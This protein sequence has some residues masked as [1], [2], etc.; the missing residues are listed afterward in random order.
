MDGLKDFIQMRDLVVDRDDHRHASRPPRIA[1]Q[2]GGA[3]TRRCWQGRHRYGHKGS[4]SNRDCCVARNA[5][6]GRL[7]QILHSLAKKTFLQDATGCELNLLFSIYHMGSARLSQHCKR[8]SGRACRKK[9]EAP[10]AEGAMLK[11][12][13]FSYF[14]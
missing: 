10:S 5:M 12:F 3:V 11:V 1:W 14:G 4:E 2:C 7:T 9:H 13:R 8:E 6:L